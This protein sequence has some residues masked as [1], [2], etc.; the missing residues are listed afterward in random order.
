MRIYQLFYYIS[1]RLLGIPHGQYFINFI[2]EKSIKSNHPVQHKL[3]A[4][5]SYQNRLVSIPL[6]QPNV[7]QRIKI[8]YN[9]FYRS[10]CSLG[11]II[12]KK[13]QI[14]WNTVAFTNFHV[15]HV[16]PNT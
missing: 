1:F 7:K 14:K 2:Y 6:T 4:F 5:H 3:V 11:V 16:T 15:L 10:N 9:I 8:I 13:K 12:R